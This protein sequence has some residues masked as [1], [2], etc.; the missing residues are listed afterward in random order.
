[1]AR[2]RWAGAAAVAVLWTTVGAGMALTGL[3]FFDEKPISYLGTDARSV[4]VFRV[5]LLLGA[6]LLAAFS[7]YVRN[8][9]SAPVS[10]L[11][12][13]LIGLAGQVVA[14]LV[15][16]SGPGLAHEIHTAGGLVLGVSLPV[17]MWRFAAGL[18]VGHWR[19]TAYRLCW[20]EVTACAFGLLLSYWGK[21]PIAEIVPAGAFHLWIAVVTARSVLLPGGPPDARCPSGMAGRAPG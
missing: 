6:A 7:F 20:L 5:G 21:A 3:G 1:M 2:L 18:A 15:S 4:V 17:L 12:A 16:I 9:F 14:A 13:S 19:L 10:F 8:I 11:A